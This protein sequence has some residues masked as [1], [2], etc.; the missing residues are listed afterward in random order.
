[1][2][3]RMSVSRPLARGVAPVFWVVATAC[4]GTTDPVQQ[5]VATDPRSDAAATQSATEVPVT[6][7]AGTAA[8]RPLLCGEGGAAF[9]F[10]YVHLLN[11]RASP[12]GQFPSRNGATYLRV[13]GNCDYWVLR[14][15]DRAAVHEGSLTTSDV[16]QLTQDVRWEAWPGWYSSLVKANVADAT[17]QS[18]WD[19]AGTFGCLHQCLEPFPEQAELAQELAPVVAQAETWLDTLYARGTPLEGPVRILGVDSHSEPQAWAEGTLISW[20]AS[21]DLDS[22]VFEQETAPIGGVLVEDPDDAAWLR[23]LNIDAEAR[24]QAIGSFAAWIGV[25][26]GDRIIRLTISDALPQEDSEGV[27]PRPF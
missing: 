14:G 20:Q 13:D 8:P 19:S 12:A 10:Q 21:F 23:Q 5:I 27:V 16:E 25:Q 18:F 17:L 9:A 22:I 3:Q 7:S 24:Y 2:T 11:D 4:G 26:D 15:R 6:P 1:V